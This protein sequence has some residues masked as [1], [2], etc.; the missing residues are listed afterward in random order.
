MLGGHDGSGLAL[1]RP[2]SFTSTTSDLLS[3]D[4]SHTTL[5]LGSVKRRWEIQQDG[6][7]VI[8]LWVL[9]AAAHEDGPGASLTA[10]GTHA[11][12]AAQRRRD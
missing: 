12:G 11:H 4:P 3:R 8:E 6:C 5:D 1:P 2:A 7:V 10:F 9:V